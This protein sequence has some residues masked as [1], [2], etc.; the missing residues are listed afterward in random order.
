MDNSAQNGPD[1]SFEA[2]WPKDSVVIGVDEAGR[3]PW[4][5]PVVASAFW[6]APDKLE[7]L[8]SSLT[9]SKKLSA[10][11]RAKIEAT[12]KSQSHQYAIGTVSA[13]EIDETGLLTATF[14]AMDKAVSALMQHCDRDIAAILVDGNLVPPLPSA[15]EA[16]V[17]AII[18]GDSRSLSIAAASIMAKEA[19]DRHMQTLD[20]IYP[21]YGFAKHKGY[22]TKAHQ[23]ALLVHGI[24]PEH[25][26][27]FKPIQAIINPDSD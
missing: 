27:S 22:G 25:R 7:S 13:A 19:R 3:G 20:E 17:K 12:L 5:G 1:Y 9:D 24:C 14:H 2:E 26:K 18:K 16:H 10:A 21:D 23:Q 8:P 4:A 6:I 15:P 11:V